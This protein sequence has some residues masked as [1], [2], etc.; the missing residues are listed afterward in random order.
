[1]SLP[2]RLR[3]GRR[4]V[5][6]PKRGVELSGEDGMLS[7]RTSVRHVCSPLWETSPRSCRAVKRP[8]AE[9]LPVAVL[10]SVPFTGYIEATWRRREWPPPHD[11]RFDSRR[12]LGSPPPQCVGVHAQC[13]AMMSSLDAWRRRPSAPGLQAESHSALGLLTALEC[14]EDLHQLRHLPNGAT[15]NDG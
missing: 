1:M 9:A 10:I 14:E 12:V 4:S 15:T 13:S 7:Q 11:G 5:G 6:A 8:A 2:T 3:R